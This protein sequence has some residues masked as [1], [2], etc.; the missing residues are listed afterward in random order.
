MRIY[1]VGFE[2]LLDKLLVAREDD[3]EVFA[4]VLHF[5][6]NEVQHLLAV[7]IRLRLQ[8]IRSKILK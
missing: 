8:L 7:G 4:L 2:E 1:G 5:V 3:D 6:H